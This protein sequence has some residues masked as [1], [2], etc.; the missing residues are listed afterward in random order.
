M[1]TLLRQ[2]V[3]QDPEIKVLVLSQKDERLYASRC[4]AAG[5]RGYLM[6]EQATEEVYTAIQK[7]LA[8]GVYLSRALAA[9]VHEGAT[10]EAHPSGL[11]LLS[12]RELQVFEMIGRGMNT[13][14][15]SEE[16]KLGIKTV[17]THREGIKSKLRLGD[18]TQ[19]V[20]FAALWNQETLRP[21]MCG[22]AAA[23]RNCSP[24]RM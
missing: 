19:L 3:E 14:Q 9:L 2:L 18:I 17:E 10:A 1:E 8:G 22:H 23:A 6:K 16:L 11:A 5:A 7:V 12:N 13:K 20:R 15:I 24:R 4:L 21:E